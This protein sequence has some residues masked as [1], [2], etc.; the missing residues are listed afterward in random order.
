MMSIRSPSGEA[1]ITVLDH[2]FEAGVVA[3]AC[4]DELGEHVMLTGLSV[5]QLRSIGEF[6]I[7]RAN[8]LDRGS[9][10]DVRLSEETEAT[11]FP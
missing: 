2:G 5:E 7:E 3:L 11:H 6:L 9:V 8:C 4:E 1:T 10:S